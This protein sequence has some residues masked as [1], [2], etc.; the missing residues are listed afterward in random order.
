VILAAEAVASV[1]LD[2]AAQRDLPTQ[3]V[4]GQDFPSLP[5]FHRPG[6]PPAVLSERFEHGRRYVV[7]ACGACGEPLRERQG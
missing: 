2:G 7:Y 6:N 4:G 3:V 1:A 5:H